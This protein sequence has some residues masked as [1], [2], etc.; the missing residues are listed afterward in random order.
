MKITY[1]TINLLMFLIPGLVSCKV[2][3]LF[4]DRKQ[5]FFELIIETLIYNYLIYEIV[6]IV[7]EWKAL[8]QI[9]KSN[10]SYAYVF[11]GDYK[12]FL[13]VFGTS[14]LLPIIW[15]AIVHHDCHMK[16][17][18]LIRSTN[19]TSRDS[20]WDDV[21][22]EE[23]RFLTLHLTDGRRISGWPMYYSKDKD[24]G[25]IYLAQAGWLGNDGKYEN[26]KSH[27]ILFD[28]N[29]IDFIEFMEKPEEEKQ[30]D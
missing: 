4:I 10:N 25:F 5:S 27:G 8:I 28:T 22:I 15:G 13:L 20:A 21:F 11:V 24:D 9:S 30:S 6:N 17:L 2:F 14:I 23:V 3:S 7:I 12:R 26:I 1:E 29:K 16:F 19:K 18:R